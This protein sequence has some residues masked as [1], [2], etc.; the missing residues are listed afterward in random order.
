MRPPGWPRTGGL[1]ATLEPK[2]FA[3]GHLQRPA[4]DAEGHVRRGRRHICRHGAE[5]EIVA[6]WGEQ[7]RVPR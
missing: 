1:P 7:H 3:P 2:H 6:T 4:C 5:W